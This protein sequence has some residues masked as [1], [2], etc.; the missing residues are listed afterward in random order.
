MKDIIWG[1]IVLIFAAIFF[2]GIISDRLSF[3]IKFF[4]LIF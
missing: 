4:K 2:L 1:I 3:V